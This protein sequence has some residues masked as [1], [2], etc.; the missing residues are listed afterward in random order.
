MR[1]LGVPIT[2]SRLSKMECQILADKIIGKIRQWSTRNISFVGRAQLI[3][4]VVFG[5]YSFWASIFILPKEVI[6]NVNQLCRNC[7]WGGLLTSKELH[8]LHGV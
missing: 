3:N 1:Y 2:A 8:L 7:L 6:D 5:M 4:S